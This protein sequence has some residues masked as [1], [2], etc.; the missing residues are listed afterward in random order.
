MTLYNNLLKEY[1]KQQMMYAS[2]AIIGQSCL[3][4]VAVLVILMSDPPKVI[5][6]TQLFF[7]TIACMFFNGAVLSQQTNKFAFNTL[8]VS[9]L[10]SA[11]III[12]HL[13]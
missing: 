2:F 9:V 4:S 11:T 5:L 8:L 3:G 1:G 13:F 10:L 12:V 7:V 6:L